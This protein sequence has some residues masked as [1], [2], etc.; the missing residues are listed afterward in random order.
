MVAD[1]CL[2]CPPSAGRQIAAMASTM[3]ASRSRRFGNLRILRILVRRCSVTSS[4][5]QFA[6]E[7]P[8]FSRGH[9]TA[10]IDVRVWAARSHRAR[11]QKVVLQINV[12]VAL[13]PALPVRDRGAAVE[14]R[15]ERRGLSRGLL[16]SGKPG[17]DSGRT[18]HTP[19]PRASTPRNCEWPPLGAA[20]ADRGYLDCSALPGRPGEARWLLSDTRGLAP[21]RSAGHRPW[22]GCSSLQGPRS[23]VRG[24]ARVCF[25]P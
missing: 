12:L 16:R 3:I 5:E 21:C 17:R 2:S 23:L 13:M 7:G 11:T 18:G 6:L 15:E 8:Y 22:R 14:A 10:Q 4:R 1:S 20:Y 25:W 9:R 24:L 19:A